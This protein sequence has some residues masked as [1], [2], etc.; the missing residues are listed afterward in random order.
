M[1][2]VLLFETSSSCH[3]PST[4]KASI[5]PGVDESAEEMVMNSGIGDL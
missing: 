1:A 5:D 3:N 4:I 2:I